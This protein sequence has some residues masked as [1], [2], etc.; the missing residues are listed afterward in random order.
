MA[1]LL[2]CCRIS[3]RQNMSCPVTGLIPREKNSIRASWALVMKDSQLN[4]RLLLKK[5][6]IVHPDTQ[7]YFRFRNV[8]VDNLDEDAIFQSHASK[9]VCAVD[10]IVN[11]L[12]K[13]DDI[14]DILLK[15][16]QDHAG[17]G[18]QPYNY[19]EF[20]AVM[21][22]FLVERL[23]TLLTDFDRRC[24]EKL[25]DFIVQGILTGHKMAF[26]DN[27]NERRLSI[28]LFYQGSDD[29]QECRSSIPLSYQGSHDE[30]EH[31]L[32]IPL[33]YRGSDDVQERR[34]SI[35]LFYQGSDDVQECRLSI[36]LSY[37]GSHDEQ[38]QRLRMS[39]EYPTI[40]SRLS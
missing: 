32:S 13:S 19:T 35:P 2:S 20:K 24:W 4:G 18:V 39:F 15:T 40:L 3:N 34:L 27:N 37:H 1:S 26:R 6:F 38:E 21:E 28:P 11:G 9:V 30:Q 12:D 10:A 36:P 29:V 25:L 5:L 33:F 23:G 16:G 22:C 8:S 17:R 7:Q 14:V 31:R